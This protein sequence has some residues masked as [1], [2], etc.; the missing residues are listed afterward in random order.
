MTVSKKLPYEKYKEIYSL[1]PR[2]TVEVLIVED[3][4]ILLTKRSIEPV[5]GFWHTPGGAVLKG[6]KIEETVKR[7]AKEEVGLDIEIEK[8]CGLIEYESL[9]GY[10]GHDI[11]LAFLCRKKN[12]A[13]EVKLDNNAEDYDFFSVLPEKMIPE[14][15]KIITDL[16]ILN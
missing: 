5:R 4:K 3:G 14:Q 7:V 16:K 1:V 8:F 11:S 12:K 10:F 2:L 6:E 13:Q 15:R 9:I